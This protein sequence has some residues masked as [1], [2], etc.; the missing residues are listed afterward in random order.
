LLLFFPSKFPDGNWEPKAFHFE[1]VWLSAEDGTRSHAWYC[2]CDKP[3]A[4]ILYAHGNGGNLSYES[5][6]L[7]YFQEDLHVS[8]LVFDYRGYGRSEGVPTV[9]GVLEDAR[10]ARS[11]LAR[12]V[13]IKETQ[14]V[15]MGRSLG[16]AVV[17]QLAAESPARGLIVESAFSS[18]RDM[19]SYY[20]PKLAWLV[21]PD[22]LDSVSQ[23]A[24]YKGPLLQSHG[25]ADRT[26]PYALGLK[27]FKAANQPKRFVAIP[28]GDHNDH[29]PADYCAELDRFIATLPQD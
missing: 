9:K 12:R 26:V 4:Y 24:R 23:I 25:D 15:L 7:K 19:A 1:D 29:R 10:A 27:L 28:G 5:A 14:I 3:R 13:A 20:Y 22:K 6:L 8:A 16:G 18:L 21:P 17:V 2:P 11:I